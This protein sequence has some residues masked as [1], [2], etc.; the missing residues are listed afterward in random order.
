MIRTYIYVLH[1]MHRNHIQQ[2]QSNI[3]V[4]E[5]DRL[6]QGQSHN[7][8]FI[9]FPYCTP[10]NNAP[11]WPVSASEWC[12]QN[13]TVKKLWPLYRFNKSP[14]PVWLTTIDPS[15]CGAQSNLK[16]WGATEPHSLIQIWA[17]AATKPAYSFILSSLRG[18]LRTVLMYPGKR[19]P[20]QKPYLLAHAKV[21]R[22]NLNE[23]EVK[24]K[25]G[26]L[27]EHMPLFTP[28]E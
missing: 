23:L 13:H 5:E 21:Q 6:G 9:A 16:C 4:T 18:R 8:N 17:T 11:K 7:I 27:K 26:A 19:Q 22:A 3:N 20:K 12:L 1:E 10:T 25:Q 15:F 14:T 28:I 24:W 2:S